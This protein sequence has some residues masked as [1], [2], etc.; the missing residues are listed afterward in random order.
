MQCLRNRA[1]YFA[2]RLEAAMKGAGTDDCTLIRMIVSRCEIDL[3][4]I[5]NEYER[6][7]HRTLYSAVK[8]T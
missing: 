1:D 8:V 7:Y 6:R 5:K 3:G 4:T 2:E